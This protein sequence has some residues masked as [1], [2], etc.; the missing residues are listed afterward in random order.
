MELELKLDAARQW[1]KAAVI[2]LAVAR[3]CTVDCVRCGLCA[4]ETVCILHCAFWTVH[5]EH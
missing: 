5:S 3:C 1:E 4:F 2:K